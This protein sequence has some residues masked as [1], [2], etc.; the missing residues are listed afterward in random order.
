[1]T[2][3]KV[4][5]RA[6]PTILP[7]AARGRRKPPGAR[8]RRRPGLEALESRR[9]LSVN[10]AEFPLRV[11]GG[12]P[13]GVASGAGSDK[14]I[15]FTLS[16]NNIGMIN[17]ANTKAG[18]T[19]YPIPTYNSGPGPIAAGP[20]GNYW[21]FEQ[22]ANQFGAINPTTGQITEIPLPTTANPGLNG[23]TA[24]PNGN[25]W[26]TES[27]MNQ[28]GMI[29]TAT[30]QIT[31]FTPKTPGAQPYGI[32]EGPDGNI[33]FTEAGAN[34]IG[35]ID[36]ITHIV[37]E[38]AIDSSGN[39]NAEGITVGPDNNLWFTL[40]GTDT[41]GVM[42]K[43]GKLL[44]EYGGLTKG[45]APNAIV[46]GPD[47]NLWFTE[48]GSGQVGMMTPSGTLKQVT[49]SVG[50]NSKPGGIARGSDNNLWLVASNYIGIE[51]IVP[52]S[53]KQ[54]TYG[55][56]TT[57]ANAATGI[58]ADAK[59][60]LWFT[61][62]AADQVGVFNPATAITTEYPGGSG[63]YGPL[64]IAHGPDGNMW[65]TEA[66]DVGC[67]SS[68]SDIG[69]VT[70]SGQ[71]TQH[72]VQ[73]ANSNPYG[74]VYD[75]F[76]G[77][78]WYTEPAADRVGRINP[79]NF[80]APD[81][82]VPTANARP[83]A[84]AVDASG[85]LWFVENGAARIGEFS[86]NNPNQISEYNIPGTPYGIVAGPDGNI[87]F[88]EYASGYK[89]GVFSP[90]S[91]KVIAQYALPSGHNAGTIIVGPDHNLWFADPTGSIGTITTA[92]VITEYPLTRAYPVAL[93]SAP[94]GNIWFTG[95][96]TQMP[97][98]C[99]SYPN[100]IGVLTL[101]STATPTQLA[102][103]TQPPGSVT[104]AKGFGL[105][106]SVE[107]SSGNPDLDYSGSVT[108]ALANDPTGDTLNGTL[109]EPV[110][111]GV[112]VFNGLTL[113][114][115]G[116]GY[117]IQAT[118]SG[119]TSVTTS[120]FNVTL[121]ATKLLVTTEP[122]AS[123]GAGTPF[124][125]VVSAED[126]QG[127]VDTS[128]NG[129]IT[130]TLGNQAAGSTLSGVLI[131]GANNGVATFTGLSLN[132]PFNDY[133]IRAS[134]GSLNPAT[135]IGF[136][137]TT[138]PATKLAVGAG[139]APPSSI[140]AGGL[141]NVTIVAEDQYG[142][143]ATGFNGAVT[144][145]LVN[146]G[147]VTLQGKTTGNA[148]GGQITFTGLSIYAA[149]TGYQIQA[150][151]TNSGVTAV[152]TGFID[153]TA[154]P[155]TQLVIEPV[156]PA[157]PL[158]AGTNF[159]FSVD[160]EDQYANRDT[161]FNGT[162]TI[163]LVNAPGVILHGSNTATA[164]SGV[165]TFSSL[166]ITTA[167]TYT[168]QATS[169]SLVAGTTSPITVTA[170]QVDGL[171]VSQQPPSPIAAGGP[172]GLA[173]EGVDQYGNPIGSFAGTVTVA[174]VNS[175]GVTLNGTLSQAAQGGVAAF[176]GL[177]ITKAGTYTIQATSGTLTKA[178]SNSI[179]VTAAPPGKLVIQTPP[180]S[181]ATAGKALTTQ[182]V[183]AIE[184]ANG[185]IETGD[186]STQ[187]KVSL[188]SGPG[189][190]LGAATVTVKN[191][192]ATFTDLSDKTAGTI[193]LQFS[194][195]GLTAGPS[196]N[197]VISPDV[198]SQLV[199]H[200]QPPST[201]S[202]G[203]AFSPSPMI[204]EEDQYGNIET[205]DN[206]TIITAMP[207]TGAGPLQGAT[208]TVSGGVA[209]FAGLADPTM[210]TITLAF[211]GGG[212]T[213]ATS[214]PV[215]V[216]PGAPDHLVITTQPYASVVAGNPLTDPIVV[217]ERD[218]YGNRVTT[219]NSTVV[220]ASLASGGGTLKGAT[221]ATM[222]GGVASFDNIE[223]D[224]VG[225]LTLRFS[226]GTLPPV[227]SNPSTVSPAAASTLAIV[228]RPP[229]G[230][231]AG[232]KFAVTVDAFDPYGNQA[233]SFNGPV[234]V[235]LATGSGGTLSGTL[236][237][238]ASAGEA[239][240]TDLVSTQSGSISLSASSANLASAP[241]TDPIPVSPDVA[242]QVV[243]HVQP[244]ATAT[245]GQP[246]AT[247]PVV[248]VTD[249]YGNLETGDSSTVVSVASSAGAGPLQ[250][251]TTATVSGGVATFTD[252]AEDIA[253][254]LSLQF[255]APGL[256]AA[257]S[258]NIVVSPAVASKLV[259][260]TQ[261]SATATAGTA[262]ATQPV[263][264]VTDRYGNLETGD[265]STAVSASLGSG[266]GPLQG[267]TSVT[268]NGGVAT[269]ADLADN[270]AETITLAFASGGLTPASSNAIVVN[271]AAAAQLVIQAQPSAT[272]AAGRPFASEP[273]LE[274]LDRFGN[275]VTTDNTTVVTASPSSGV[276]PLQGA[277]ATVKG[278]VATFTG[279]ADDLVETI[280]L[281][282]S[283]GGLTAGPTPDIVV[284]PGAVSKLVMQ[285]QPSS[286]ATAGQPFATQPVVYVEDA[287]GNLETT[288]NSTVVAAS[289]S[290]AGPLQGTTTAT[291]KG[292]VAT[293][294]NLADNKAGTMTLT[295]SSG[296]LTPAT[297]TA[298]TVSAASATQLVVTTPPPSSLAAGQP[299][300]LVVS[301][302]DP[303]GN[304]VTS[305]DGGVT[306]SLPGH[307]DFSTKPAVGG[308][309]TFS[310]L[311]LD[312]TAQGG[313]IQATGAGLT[314]VVTPVNIS[315]H[316]TPAIT[317]EQVLMSRKMKKGKP[318]GKAVL[319]G[320]VLD[321]SIAMNPATAGSAANYT[322]GAMPAKH[323][324]KK[325]VPT[326]IP[327][328]VTA[329]YDPVKHSVTLTIAGKQTFAKGGQITVIYAPP[330]GVSSE[331]NI[332]LDAGDA[333]FTILSKATGIAAG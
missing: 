60:N 94:D 121:G 147:G 5:R 288:D 24:G 291:A 59:G 311:T 220:T 44:K 107:N 301:A 322:V 102:V 252:L 170:G 114:D 269:F 13:Q 140:I 262:F 162:V 88:T 283:G 264:Y 240:F 168:I 268:V 237:Q 225:T 1:M 253:G 42:D 77:N 2:S 122:P 157:G 196:N 158:S 312:A 241:P 150:T 232:S 111:N 276:G 40:A 333:R 304:V 293:F 171:M 35:M 161:T 50:F 75:S 143:P 53:Q 54:T 128:Y 247:Q 294:T 127:N 266:A 163:G 188:A 257:Q 120:P 234:T 192:I 191:G 138:G 82:A 86:P 16:S 178:T 27:N 287:Y 28:I 251:T 275:L 309:A 164:K 244:S 219:D 310:G 19:Q 323:G 229:G 271:P 65:F 326:L 81:Y 186:N 306:I 26:F 242:S 181:T 296:G 321:F 78:F 176:S 290:G 265:S 278:G 319:Q 299:F 289:A 267:A 277:T 308:A 34:Q 285:T 245:A 62:Q 330:G 109:T 151:T 221:T 286:T 87:W 92:G 89:I 41:I 255:S 79:T 270:K 4:E 222:T 332:P 205:G 166:A 124:G 139:G 52:S 43:T 313:S 112:A 195:G 210:E 328:P 200:T 132:V 71:I 202:A 209:T 239:N 187:I 154:G 83:E 76:D 108:I 142:D 235:A 212:L 214:N 96:G 113:K 249:R 136:D 61:Q 133:T 84:I 282:F 233:T 258:S 123:L 207:V 248:Y 115:A 177:S 17:P 159:G 134:S 231:V 10:I 72:P 80:S 260:Q 99:N 22:A 130:L 318:V 103:S 203:V 97:G 135:T 179:L 11:E 208:A 280:A 246:F 224:K 148:Q 131:V 238:T 300:T 250:G 211:N 215:A 37:Q 66:G 295:I 263:V 314:S 305:F 49:A 45:A 298:I 169:G 6:S 116:A 95:T 254:T 206:S 155:A 12:D 279:L 272:A 189:T 259:V 325:S 129:P 119:L 329:L 110:V 3:H 185:N 39:D 165:A 18:I 173:I 302:E 174:L 153:V 100:V 317:S 227:V 25:I 69:T 23:I 7:A 223:N 8:R 20:D 307:P 118:A 101:A 183:I 324:K 281:Q 125:L 104:A 73:T 230:I 193:T 190:L 216:G 46:T 331:D 198:A 175:P 316:P 217:E 58:A 197:I 15:W 213:S 141:F 85:N 55:Y 30:H 172:F 126:G 303:F 48:P 98:C 218:K 228:S 106:V 57:S 236:T 64:G 201:A 167:G 51:S 32:V 226:A 184:D 93:E 284:G 38:F 144:L 47:N 145:A 33:W 274:E 327:V 137:V 36:P 63:V 90:S 182:P 273:V 243:V 292:G 320:F 21:F 156:T 70:P 91:N 9:L 194:G 256:A 297:S 152:T 180:S 117:T 67:C 261:P 160:A 31:E 315:S 105:V 68:G 149:R 199:I 204:Y 74:I 146:G 14:N 56:T 29:N